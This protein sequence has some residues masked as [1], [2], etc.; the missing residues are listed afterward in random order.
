M[1]TEDKPK[2]PGGRPSKYKPE[3]IPQMI[4]FFSIEPSRMEEGHMGAMVERP[5]RLPTFERF[6]SNIDV[7]VD[8]LLNWNK[9]FP[10]FLGAY[11]KCK[12]MQKDFMVQNGM[13][14]LFNAAFTKFVAINITDMVDKSEVDQNVNVVKLPEVTLDDG[15]P[16][17]LNIG[18]PI[19]GTSA[20]TDS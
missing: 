4:D 1:T 2:H 8:T 15:K 18:E 12:Q 16:L 7:T 11:K 9:S 17:K 14:G 20:S 6:A 10:E 13:S 5:N 3:F 19:A